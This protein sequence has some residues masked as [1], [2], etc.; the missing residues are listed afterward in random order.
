MTRNLK[1]ERI[2]VVVSDKNDK[3]ITIHVD[4]RVKHPKYDKV[5]HRTSKLTAHDEKNESKIGDKVK[6]MEMRR[7]SKTKKWRLVKILESRK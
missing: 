5:M 4:R 7:L 6:V 3:T 1:K 2:G